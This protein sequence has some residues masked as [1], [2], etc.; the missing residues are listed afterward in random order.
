MRIK[1]QSN[2]YHT[3]YKQGSDHVIYG[4]RIKD[5]LR[6]YAKP[7]HK[8]KTMGSSGIILRLSNS[9]IKLKSFLERTLSI[10]L[11]SQRA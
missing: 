7:A 9:V 3:E 1:S 4:T 11:F 2:L 6:C 8:L 10:K 5:Y